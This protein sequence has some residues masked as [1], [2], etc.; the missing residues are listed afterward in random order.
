MDLEFVDEAAASVFFFFFLNNIHVAQIAVPLHVM[1][2]LRHLWY[3][4]CHVCC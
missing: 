2:H 1:L 3:L 4:L